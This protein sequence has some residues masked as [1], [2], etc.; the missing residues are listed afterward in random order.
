MIAFPTK[1]MVTCE[2]G[3]VKSA[4]WWNNS[5]AKPVAATDCTSGTLM[6]YAA[7]SF[8]E[9]AKIWR[10]ECGEC[11][12]VN[13]VRSFNE[14]QYYKMAVTPELQAFAPSCVKALVTPVEVV[15]NITSDEDSSSI[16]TNTL[17][18]IGAV[19]GAILLI[20]IIVGAVLSLGKGGDDADD[21]DTAEEDE[22]DEEA[23]PLDP[24]AAEAEE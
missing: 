21:L 1:G 22:E 15:P 6:G 17:I 20:A 11:P 3:I 24:E 19:L 23:E 7:C 2:N 16:P 5:G 9:Q 4:A 12:H 13:L 10:G 14:T 8:A 18:I